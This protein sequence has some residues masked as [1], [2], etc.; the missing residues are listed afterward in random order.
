M[1]DKFHKCTYVRT[2]VGLSAYFNFICQGVCILGTNY[3]K[4]IFLQ[5]LINLFFVVLRALV[6]V[7]ETWI[8]F[9]SSAV[10]CLRAVWWR[11]CIIALSIFK[12]NSGPYGNNSGWYLRVLGSTTTTYTNIDHVS[13]DECKK[14]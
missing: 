12:E 14:A 9:H 1:C 7:F 5:L 8:F 3:K 13:L 6:A 2:Y 10:D 4:N 11:I